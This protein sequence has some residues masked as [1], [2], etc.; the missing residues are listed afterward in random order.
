MGLKLD[1]S[2]AYDKMEWNFLEETLK[3]KGFHRDFIA[4]IMECISSVFYSVLL[5]GSHYGNFFPSRRLRQVDPLSPY[6]F[7]ICM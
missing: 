2:K 6:L 5:N 1:M 3:V 7:I 4:I